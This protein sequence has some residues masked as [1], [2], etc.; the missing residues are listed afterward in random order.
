MK[1]NVEVRGNKCSRY[2]CHTDLSGFGVSTTLTT[3][4]LIAF[5]LGPGFVCTCSVE[6]KKER[7]HHRKSQTQ[8]IRRQNFC[9]VHENPVLFFAKSKSKLV[10]G[11]CFRHH[12]SHPHLNLFFFP[13]ETNPFL[14]PDFCI[15][16]NIL[17]F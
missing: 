1:N 12:T 15:S 11:Y 4:V 13:F 2:F 7:I 17:P 10:R 9:Q 14:F 5:V 8:F 6:N 16:D 3:Q